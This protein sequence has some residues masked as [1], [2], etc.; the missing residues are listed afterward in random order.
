MCDC[1]PTTSPDPSP[2]S[3]AIE[4]IQELTAE[5]ERLRQQLSSTQATVDMEVQNGEQEAPAAAPAS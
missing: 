2:V 4:Q 3:I 5:A 1:E